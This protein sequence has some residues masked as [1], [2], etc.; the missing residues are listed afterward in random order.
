MDVNEFARKHRV[1]MTATLV[2]SNPNMD[3]MPA[4]STHWSCELRRSLDVRG[5][6]GRRLKR[7][8]TTYFSMGPA[9]CKEPTVYDLLDCLASDACTIENAPT[10]EEFARDLGYDE[11]SR[12]AERIYKVCQ[13]QTEKLRQF[14]GEDAFALL[15]FDTERL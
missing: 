10:F 15:V 5:A 8:L 14:L 12:K 4:G 11:D 7:T 2:G 6:Q 9:H 13:K 1:T 3:D